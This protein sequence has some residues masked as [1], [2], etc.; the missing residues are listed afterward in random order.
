M[1]TGGPLICSDMKWE[2]TK[3]AQCSF[4]VGSVCVLHYTG[5]IAVMVTWPRGM[6]V[7]ARTTL[8]S[9]VPASTVVA[10]CMVDQE[11]SICG[12][13]PAAIGV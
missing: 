6:S 2:R 8:G 10:L 4:S 5:A 3:T 1:R 13:R 7:S 9:A 12:R 11:T